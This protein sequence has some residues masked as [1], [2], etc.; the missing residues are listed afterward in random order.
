MPRWAR[1]AQTPAQHGAATSGATARQVLL[2]GVCL[3][4][5]PVTPGSAA[6][7]GGAPAQVVLIVATRAL[8]AR[9]GS[10]GPLGPHQH[11]RRAAPPGGG[12]PDTFVPT[13]RVGAVGVGERGR[14]PRHGG[15]PAEH[16]AGG[17][18]TVADAVPDVLD[19]VVETPPPRI[20]WAGRDRRTT[21]GSGR[22]CWVCPLHGRAHRGGAPARPHR[23]GHTPSPNPTRRTCDGAPGGCPGRRRKGSREQVSGRAPTCGRSRT[24]RW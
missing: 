19:L 21:G 8:L 22:R 1:W 16:A 14:R 24:R 5:L 6:A 4:A 15:S 2:P 17:E 18:L 7:G 10:R 12:G 23:A 9:H 13:P 20:C 3:L 11:R